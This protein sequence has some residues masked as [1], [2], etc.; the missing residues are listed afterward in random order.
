MDIVVKWR[1]MGGLQG[2]HGPNRNGTVQW[3]VEDVVVRDPGPPF[4]GFGGFLQEYIDLH[5][6]M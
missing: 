3:W 2:H 6:R 1:E 4:Q 5:Y